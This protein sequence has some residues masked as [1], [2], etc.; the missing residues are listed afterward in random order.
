[1]GAG[2]LY[3]DNN[4][5]NNIYCVSC[6]HL[7]DSENLETFKAS[8][9]IFDY[10]NNIISQTAEFKIIGRDI[11]TDVIVGLYDPELSY[12]KVYNVDLS[13]FEKLKLIH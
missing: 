11:F 4:N 8:F 6:N 7:L 9:E 3:K 1:V 10:T 2:F 12:N 13:D 5:P